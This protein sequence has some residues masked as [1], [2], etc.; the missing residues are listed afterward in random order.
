MLLAPLEQF[1]IL[2]ILRLKSILLNLDFSITNFLVINL[3]SLSIIVFFKSINQNSTLFIYFIPDVWQKFFESITTIFIAQLIMNSI[4]V[5]SNKYFLVISTVFNFILLSN[6]IGLIPYTFTT[7]SHLYVTF[8]LSFSVFIGINILIGHKYRLKTL[9]LF[10][11]AN[12][13]I[14]LAVILVPIELISY[15][16]KPISLG[17]RLFINLMAGHTLLKVIIGFSLEL[18]SIESFSSLYSLLPM[19]TLLILF[20]LELAV[21][22]IQAYVFITLTCIYIQ[23]GN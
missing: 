4:L 7:T 21:G 8:T 16:A 3:L 2:P 9:L 17:V 13:S 23:D 22:L 20:F 11:P 10:F 18:L 5:D 19:F 12:T 15:L 6:L 14:Y 1:E